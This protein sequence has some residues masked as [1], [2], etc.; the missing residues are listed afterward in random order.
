MTAEPPPLGRRESNSLEFKGRD[1]LE[2]PAKIARG[3]VAMLNA[4][5]DEVREIWIG[6]DENNEIATRFEPIPE[7][8]VRARQLHDHLV[9]SIEPSLLDREVRIECVEVPGGEVLKLSVRGDDSRKPYAHLREGARSY[10]VRSGARI[11]GMSREEVANSFRKDAGD[12]LDGAARQWLIEMRERFSSLRD[13]RFWLAIRPERELALDLQ[14]LKR[15]NLLNDPTRSGNRASG[16]T[17]ANPLLAADIQLDHL[18]VGSK[19]L[20]LVEVYEH[21]GILYSAPLEMLEHHQRRREDEERPIYPFALLEYTVSLFRLARTL[22][23]EGEL[24]ENDLI[25]AETAIYRPRGWRL[26]PYSPQAHAFQSRKRFPGESSGDRE[27]DLIM[28]RPLAFPWVELAEAND[29]CAFRLI[30]L[31]YQAFGHDED[32]IPAEFDKK[33]W[34]LRIGD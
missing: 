10:L 20:G 22:Y 12:S 7:A 11:R 27:E 13:E 14:D 19:E 32:R 25:L 24:A 26:W 33:S 29:R 3:V 5:G 16:W 4:E 15:R 21:G 2:R 6:I 18:R 23:S 1:A 28:T 17:F 30:R 31:V 9:D 34:T 8:G